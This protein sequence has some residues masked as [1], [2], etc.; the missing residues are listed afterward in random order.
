MVRFLAGKGVQ[1]ALVLLFAVTLNFMLPRMM[2]GSP[3]VFLAGGDV[4]FPPEAQR[5]DLRRSRGL[6]QPLW[7]QYVQYL[8]N[9]ATGNLGYSFQKGR[10]ISEIIVERV[11]WTLLLV[12]LALLAATLIGVVWGTLVA[13]RGG[14]GF[15]PGA[16]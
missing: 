8:G 14:R 11:P 5:T 3:L 10:P 2:P 6:A 16:L 9:L 13:W 12:G 4:G 1:Y 7:R 15:D